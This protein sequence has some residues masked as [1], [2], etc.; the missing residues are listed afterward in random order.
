MLGGS[1]EAFLT[2]TMYAY[3]ISTRNRFVASA[4]K[5]PLLH[6]DQSSVIGCQCSYARQIKITGPVLYFNAIANQML[7]LFHVD[8]FEPSE[9]DR[10]T[11]PWSDMR[12]VK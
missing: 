1:A 10:S 5:E 2:R 11:V 7:V 9:N 3:G 4:R 12:I 8:E 6:H